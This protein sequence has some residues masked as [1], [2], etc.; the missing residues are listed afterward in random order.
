MAVGLAARHWPMVARDFACQAA[1]DK[2]KHV[3]QGFEGYREPGIMQVE[4]AKGWRCR[5]ARCSCGRRCRRIGSLEFSTLL[6][7]NALV[8]VLPGCGSDFWGRAAR[9]RLWVAGCRV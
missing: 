5:G 3:P 9:R 1:N 2:L 7:Q 6:L 4:G 8:A